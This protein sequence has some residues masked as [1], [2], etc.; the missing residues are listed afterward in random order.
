M[1]FTDSIFSPFLKMNDFLFNST[2]KDM[3]PYSV[4]KKDSNIIIEVKTLGINP[5][6]ISVALTDN[7][8]TISGESHNNYSDKSFNTN[9]SFSIDDDFLS[10]IE[11]ISYKSFNGLTY[12]TLQLKT[13]QKNQI[14]IIKE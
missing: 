12:V 10:K 14:N 1:L 11:N 8:L 5:D 9:I 2:V 4:Y 7:I 6:D 13:E 3:Q